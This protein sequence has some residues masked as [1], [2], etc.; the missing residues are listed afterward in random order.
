MW[1]WSASQWIARAGVRGRPFADQYAL[2]RL[3]ARSNADLVTVDMV[4]ATLS[5]RALVELSPLR[6]PIA[7][8]AYEP[9]YRF[10]D[11]DRS[12]GYMRHDLSA[13][14]LWSFGLPRGRLGIELRADVYPPNAVVG[15]WQRSLG[16]A[17]RWDDAGA[18]E[19]IH[20]GFEEPLADYLDEVSWRD[21][22]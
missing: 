13:K 16:I 21:D 5:W 22:R 12:T 20:F 18:G 8:L 19:R 10:D 3:E 6:G 9:S 7:Y 4:R 17:L 15:S 1:F 2:A 14:L 11:D